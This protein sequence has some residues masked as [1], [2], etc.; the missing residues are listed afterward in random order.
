M[1]RRLLL[2]SAAQ[3]PRLFPMDFVE[4]FFSLRNSRY[5][6]VQF[7]M[8]SIVSYGRNFVFI[9]YPEYIIST[10]MLR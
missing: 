9:L 2:S 7:E 5:S 3:Y 10:T 4:R 1:Q 6:G 8:R